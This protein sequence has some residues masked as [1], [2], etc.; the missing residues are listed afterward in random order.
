MNVLAHLFIVT[1]T[2]LLLLGCPA[3]GTQIVLKTSADE[4]FV[5]DVSAEDTLQDL[6]AQIESVLGIPDEYQRLIFEERTLNNEEIIADMSAEPLRAAFVPQPAFISPVSEKFFGTTPTRDYYHHVTPA[7]FADIKYVITSVAN[8]NVA[9]LLWNRKALEAAGDR[10]EHIHPLKFF[11]TIFL[12]EE[13]K[14]GG[15][16]TKEFF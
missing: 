15:G 11:L 4:H 1:L 8:K 13:L 14:V 6:S 12:D 2:G 7:E 10:T 16:S 5:L 3:T 9:A